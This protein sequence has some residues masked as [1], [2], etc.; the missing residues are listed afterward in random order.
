LKISPNGNRDFATLAAFIEHD[1]L[2]DIPQ[3]VI[4]RLIEVRRKEIRP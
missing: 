2:T 1:P 3:I 4:V